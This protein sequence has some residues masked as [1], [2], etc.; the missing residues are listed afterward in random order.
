MRR[1]Q[2]NRDIKPLSEFRANASSL[3]QQVHD[4]KRPLIITHR[5]HSSAVVMD[6]AEYDDLIERMEV[7]E[8]IYTADQEIKKGKSI[9]HEK[10]KK[11]VL[12]AIS[13]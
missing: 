7:L 2:I 12:A 1:L 8:D 6:A 5:G 13:Q 4:T 9:D 3:I 10:A 11:L